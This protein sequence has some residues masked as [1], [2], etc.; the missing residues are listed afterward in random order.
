MTAED[1][2]AIRKNTD[3][4]VA[5]GIAQIR[6]NTDAAVAS[7]IQQILAAV[8]SAVWNQGV[9]AQDANGML[10]S[11][12]D[13]SPVIYP[14]SGYL[15]STNARVGG[16]TT[17]AMTDAQAQALADSIKGE[18]KATLIEAASYDTGTILDA[19]HELPEEFI[20]R[21]LALGTELAKLRQ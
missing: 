15:A 14:A 19:L 6:A 1:V 5:S 7:G 20:D 4:A 3:L 18:V 8:P 11:R 13:G 12:E 10:L 21:L 2:A 17:I 9:Q 16:N